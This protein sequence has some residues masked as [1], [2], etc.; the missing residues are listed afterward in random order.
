[1]AKAKKTAEAAIEASS[2]GGAPDT[3]AVAPKRSKVKRLAIVGVALTA[4]L[5]SGGYF[6]IPM[7]LAMFAPAGSVAAHE[8]A[9]PEKATEEAS[10]GGGHGGG[11]AAAM[12]EALPTA[13]LVLPAHAASDYQI[14]SI[15]DGEAYLATAGSIIRIKVGSTAPGLGDIIAIEASDTGGTVQGS[16]ATL[17]TS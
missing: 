16:L 17:K 9:E 3:V 12:P 6:A 11:G 14:V 8:G 2:E 1:M 4:C 7:A 15:Y 13:T 10:A 5:G